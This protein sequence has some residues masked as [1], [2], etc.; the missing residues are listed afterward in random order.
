MKSLL[1]IGGTGFLGQ[2]FFDYINKRKLK[3]FNLSKIIVISRKRKKIQTKLKTKFIKK[4]IT[5]IT[6][7]PVTNYIIYAANSTNDLE[8]LKGIDNFISLLTDKHKKTKILFTS[9][10]AV[11]GLGKTKK[12]FK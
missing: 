11:Y 1:F 2:S 3:I 7:I 4:S 8:N 6:H 12:K 10:G 5:D 9:S